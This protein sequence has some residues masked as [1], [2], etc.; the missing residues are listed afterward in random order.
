MATYPLR[1]CAMTSMRGP[2]RRVEI[3]R[4]RSVQEPRRNELS[5]EPKA[6]TN[7]HRA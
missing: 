6:L 4:A 1:R 5:P 3:W 2:M 7:A